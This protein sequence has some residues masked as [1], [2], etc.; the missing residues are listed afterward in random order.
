[1]FH[2]Y[3]KFHVSKPFRSLPPLG[4]AC[5]TNRI[6]VVYNPIYN[7]YFIPFTISCRKSNSYYIN[8]STKTGKKWEK[9]TKPCTISPFSQPRA[10]QPRGCL[11]WVVPSRSW[12][13]TRWVFGPR[14]PRIPDFSPGTRPTNRRSPAP[15]SG[16][17]RCGC[18]C[19][20]IYIFI[21][22]FLVNYLFIYIHIHVYINIWYILI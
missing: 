7:P 9:E 17:C 20:Y 3:F 1:M 12:R 16:W 19:I 6:T 15:D 2:H 10:G 14:A 21:Y 22:L 13:P 11:F 8:P 5:P 4:C 18:M